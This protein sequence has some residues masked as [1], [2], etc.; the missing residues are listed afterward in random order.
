MLPSIS[1]LHITIANMQSKPQKPETI[2]K[3]SNGNFNFKT[4]LLTVSK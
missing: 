1:N 3:L 2:C 4:N